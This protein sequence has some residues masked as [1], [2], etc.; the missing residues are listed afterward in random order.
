MCV[1]IHNQKR[2]YFETKVL[3]KLA[4][5]AKRLYTGLRSSP[6]G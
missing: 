2:L 4:I 5:G 1:Q 6:L 3:I